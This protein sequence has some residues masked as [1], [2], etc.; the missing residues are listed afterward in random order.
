MDHVRAKGRIFYPLPQE[1]PSC[2]RTFSFDSIFQQLR[3][4]LGSECGSRLHAFKRSDRDRGRS[5]LSRLLQPPFSCSKGL[6]RL[7]TSPGREFSQPF[8]GENQFLDGD[9]A[10]RPQF[11]SSGGLDGLNRS[12]GRLLSHSDPSRVQEVS[13]LR[14]PGE[15]LSVQDSVLRSVHSP[16]SIHKSYVHCCQSSSSQ[17]NKDLSLSRRLAP[18]FPVSVSVL[19]GF[20]SNSRLD[21]E[22]RTS[23]QLEEVSPISLTI[24]DLFRSETGNSSFSGFSVRSKNLG[25]SRKSPELS[26]YGYLFRKG[27]DEPPGNSGVNRK[28]CLPGETSH[29][30]P[31]ILPQGAMEQENASRLLLL[32]NLGP[33]QGGSKVVVRSK[34]IRE[35]SLSIS[36]EPEPRTVCRLVRSR[37]GSDVGCKRNF[38]FVECDR[39]RMAHQQEGVESNPPESRTLPTIRTGTNSSGSFRQHH[40]VVLHKKTGGHSFLLP[41]RGSKRPPFVGRE[42]QDS[43]PNKIHSGSPQRESGL[44]EQ[45]APGSVH[46]VDFARRSVQVAVETLGSTSGRPVRDEQIEQAPNLLLSCPGP[47]SLPDGRNATELVGSGPLRLPAV[48]D[49]R[50]G[51]EEI[52]APLQHQDD[53]D[54]PLLA[55]QGLVPSSHG[56]L[57][58]LPEEPSKQSRFTQTA[59]LQEI[60]RKPVKSAANCVQTIER[61]LRS[62]GFSK[63]AA[64]SIARARRP[65]SIK[66]Y[67]S[68]W[69]MF[70]SWCKDHDIS[71]SRTSVTQIADFL[72]FLGNKNL[73]VSTLK[74]YRS[75]LAT[76]FRHR[77]L[78]ISNNQ[79]I[80]DLIKSF[81]TSKRSDA[82]VV[83]WNL[84][85]VLKWLMSEKFEPMDSA[86]LR[87]LTRKTLFLV[88]LA[89]AKRISEIH[90]LDKRVGFSASK[91]ICSFK[92]FFMAKNETPS[93]PWPRSFE[94]PS[95]SELVG[96]EQE[97]FLCPV[98]ALKYYLR[99]TKDIRGPSDSLWCSV[100]N[101]LRPMSKNAMS[102]FIRDLI[103]EAHSNISEND[104]KMCKVKAH[105]VRAISTS[106]AYKRNLSLQDI[107]QATYWRCKSVFALHYLSQ[108]QTVFDECS[109]L[110]PFVVSGTVMGKGVKE[111]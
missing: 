103:S 90:A 85:V 49:V 72:L 7:E 92:L 105:E 76:V 24:Q 43:A 27:L 95:L 59:P 60:S 28:V 100:R 3:K 4:M 26:G 62:K 36:V 81:G 15:D 34:K 53:V 41:Q 102:F 96:K 44:L 99:R 23:N 52:S 17:R 73:S 89:T 79:D 61:L 75:M 46:R 88:L 6:R 20:E 64:Q 63:K 106:L 22:A 39:K 82:K 9:D 111:D 55:F 67:E 35:R 10:I 51:V 45:E 68:K 87:D 110:G 108:V 84:D 58:R 69:N 14:F 33:Y 21:T 13:S 42:A 78:D 104:L 5:Q 2:N 97:R 54:S 38:R 71:S 98:R 109:T 30:A 19:G 107:V 47:S 77:G 56:S 8:R 29:E 11:S 94:I 1:A 65:S 91:A 70:R 57:D 101:P 25:L 66:V 31:S 83:S 48:Q 50:C 74:G 40:S 80:T 16:S 32:S 37:M 12:A 18:S 93:H 86:S